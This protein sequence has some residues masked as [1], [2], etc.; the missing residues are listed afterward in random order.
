MDDKLRPSV[1][2]AAKACGGYASLARRLGITPQAISQWT[3][4]PL[5]RI[6]QVE[7]VT[8]IKREKLR[9]ELYR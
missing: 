4:I 1:K 6:L 7:K 5:D 8:G 2:R 9:P 3:E